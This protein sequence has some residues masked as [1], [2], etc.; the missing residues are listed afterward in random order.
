MTGDTYGQPSAPPL[1]DAETRGGGLGLR[2]VDK[3]YGE[4]LA[5]SQVSLTVVP[6]RV[7]GLVGHN[8]A[9]KSTLLRIL[10]G[11]ERP[12][13]GAVWVDG[14]I[15]TL[16]GPADAMRL[17]VSCVYQ[18]LA[19]VPQLTVSE[20]IFLG[21]ED[22]RHGVLAKRAMTRAAQELCD[23]FSV[24]VRSSALIGDL[25]VAQR[26]LVEIVAAF[27]RNTRFLLLDEP[28]TALEVGQVEHL[29]V[30]LRR[31][32][33][34]KDAAILLVDHKLSEVFS[35][36]DDIVAMADGHIVL[37]R[38][39]S[40]VDRAEVV[41]AIVGESAASVVGATVPSQVEESVSRRAGS[42]DPAVAEGVSASPGAVGAGLRVRDAR[43]A[44]LH[45]INLLVAPGRIVALYG[46]M[47]SGRSRM[48]RVL[49]GAERLT[50]GVMELDGDLY[51][52]RSPQAAMAAGVCYVC[53]D[54]KAEGIIPSVSVV[55][56]VLLP[57]LA[58]FSR[59][60]V[61]RRREARKAALEVLK[62][63][64]VRGDLSKGA[65]ALSGGNQQKVLFARALLQEPRLLL[66][67]EPTKGVDIGTKEE[68]HQ[69]IRDI[70]ETRRVPI[71]VVSSEEEEVMA[72]ADDVVIL[73]NG[74]C[75]GELLATGDLTASLLRRLALGES[76]KGRDLE[77]AS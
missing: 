77:D 56:N 44:R 58:R 63:M 43:S 59:Y 71:L 28:T 11:V 42:M 66:L 32:V 5:L 33:E 70:S 15:R 67:D 9:G 26:Q 23:D 37:E 50:S 74:S 8:G 40:N 51:N 41:A 57:V 24:G 19:L 12:D 52:P 6:G 65:L 13:A 21:Q 29:L 27:H 69:L 54:R 61:L 10:S 53:E 64:N 46:L 36:A 35:V 39:R 34:G 22:V 76:E 60:G 49:A 2:R 75:S 17:G 30:T 68:I 16:S 18:E 47:G 7:L 48:M 72:L 55:E 45:G 25:S 1:L 4:T 73:R 38:S 20:S 3:R 14:A 62:R 31:L